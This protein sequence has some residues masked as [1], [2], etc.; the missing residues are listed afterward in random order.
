MQMVTPSALRHYVLLLWPFE[1]KPTPS[2]RPLPPSRRFSR[3]VGPEQEHGVRQILL[4]A[5]F[6][7]SRIDRYAGAVV[8]PPPCIPLL[9][10]LSLALS[11][12]LADKLFLDT[13]A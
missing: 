5:I 7:L 9:R 1:W 4:H 12:T 2:S 11:F 6:M 8:S 10:S 3:Y 13:S